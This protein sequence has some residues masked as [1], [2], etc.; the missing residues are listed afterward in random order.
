MLGLAIYFLLSMLVFA[1]CIFT[2]DEEDD[3]IEK[4]KGYNVA[5]KIVTFVEVLVIGLPAFIYGML[6]AFK[7][8]E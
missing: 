6:L 1:I 2:S 4:F 3:F 8:D 7:G 5:Q